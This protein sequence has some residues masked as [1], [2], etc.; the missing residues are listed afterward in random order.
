MLVLSGC[1]SYTMPGRVVSGP[2]SMIAFVDA[3]DPQL[4]DAP[5][6]SARIAVIRDPDRPGQ[7]ASAALMSR[8]DG[9]FT[10]ELSEFGAG[11][12]EEKWE[13]SAAKPG[14]RT[15]TIRA[16]LPK[17]AAGKHLLIVLTPGTDDNGDTRSWEYDFERFR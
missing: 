11:W 13:I 3:D 7:D 16:A 12:M 6:T 2:V 4:A 17:S 8:Q 14:Y 10:L 1:G 9:S 5:I 15:A